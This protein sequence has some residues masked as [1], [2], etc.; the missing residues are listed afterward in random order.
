[1][2]RFKITFRPAGKFAIQTKDKTVIVDEGKSILEAAREGNIAINSICGGYGICGKCVVKVGDNERETLACQYKIKSD[3]V[4]RIPAFLHEQ[5]LRILEE[6][7][8]VGG[9][10]GSTAITT[11]QLTTG[12]KIVPDIYR[13]YLDIAERGRIF[14]LAADIGTT[15]V[16]V[17]LLNMKSGECVATESALN[18]QSRFGDDVISRISYAGTRA[19]L[20]EL[21]AIITTCLNELTGRLCKKSKVDRKEIYE[22]SIVGNSTMNHLFLKMPVKGL[23]RAPYKAYNVE[24]QQLY[25][26]EIGL[27]INHHGNIYTVANIASFLGSDTTAAALAAG[28]ERTEKKTL[29]VDIGTNGE[30]VLGDSNTLL[31][32]SCAAGPAFEGARISRGSRAIEGA[33][34]AVE[35]NGEDLTV[36]VI[37]SPSANEARSICGSGLID[38]VAVLVEHGIIDSTGKIVRP[39]K[40]Q[41][42]LLNRITEE[43]GQ[44]AVLIAR[45]EREILL[46]QKDIRQVQLAKAAIRAGIRILQ[47]KLGYNDEDIEQ[48]FL[49]GAFGNFIRKESALRIGLL[50]ILPTERIHFIGNAACSGAEMILL[51]SKQ[52]ELSSELAKKIEHVE[53]AREADFEEVFAKEMGF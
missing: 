23:G 18:P 46:T 2:K 17:K 6:G 50:P 28:I 41:S 49:A 51:S 3:L 8:N 9:S 11:G 25:P 27:Q 52:R 29:L 14:G 42:N 1:M 10:A 13:K 21:S 31:A 26:S 34:E 37:G 5:S 47:R 20:T 30:V 39:K 15:T 7:T 35:W 4:V 16:V 36:K 24:A 40:I 43:D 12:R 38:A 33:I 22:A 44:A 48:V 19:G 45:G 32:T 53:T